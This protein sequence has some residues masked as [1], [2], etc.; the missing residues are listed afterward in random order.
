MVAMFN[1]IEPL[2]CNRGVALDRRLEDRGEENTA[3]SRKIFGAEGKISLR[4]YLSIQE[5]SL[6]HIVIII[7]VDVRRIIDVVKFV[8]HDWM[9]SIYENY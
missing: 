8:G 2:L 4:P 6:P 9:I 3:D 1:S 7:I 5:S